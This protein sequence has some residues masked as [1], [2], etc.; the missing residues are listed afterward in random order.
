MSVITSWD[1]ISKN[2]IEILEHIIGPELQ[3]KNKILLPYGAHWIF[4]NQDNSYQNLG[5]DGHPKRGNF[6]PL[7]RGYKRMFG[8]SKLYFKKNIFI[9][10][11]IKKTMKLETCNRKISSEN[12][13]YFFELTI[14]YFREKAIVLKEHQTIVFLKSK[15][16]KKKKKKKEIDLSN[17]SLIKKKSFNYNNIDL[18]RY[19]S[20]TNNSHRI[21]YDLDY[22]KKNEG[23]K[24]I[25]V[26]GPLLAT[27][28]LNQISMITGKKIKEFSFTSKGPIYVNE[29]AV[30]KIFVSNIFKS[31][32]VIN[33]L[34]KNS[35]LV[36]Y[37]KA[38][39]E[40]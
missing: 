26:H 6:F 13:L 9:N 28:I 8:G 5:V 10:D 39:L 31:Q 25:L 14:N 12:N 1:N 3:F 22:A 23:H 7:L 24:N 15:N 34:K 29:N 38:E 16:K 32:L 40:T 17:L 37:A 20:L 18:F 27:T 36:V 35:Q 11:K 33:I 30:I 21:H 2:K 19:S 4:F